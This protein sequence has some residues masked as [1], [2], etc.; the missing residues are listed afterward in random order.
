MILKFTND[1]CIVQEFLT[2]PLDTECLGYTLA[3][4][5]KTENTKGNVHHC[6]CSN[7]AAAGN[8]LHKTGNGCPTFRRITT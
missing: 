1:I 6:F 7:T 2:N 4:K 3:A 5:L 8:L